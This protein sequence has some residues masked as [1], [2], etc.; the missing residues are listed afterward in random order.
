MSIGKSFG[1]SIKASDLHLGL[2]AFFGLLEKHSADGRAY[3]ELCR[4]TDAASPSDSTCIETS[5]DFRENMIRALTTSLL[6]SFQRL[7]ELFQQLQVR[8]RGGSVLVVY[9]GDQGAW[10]GK[11]DQK[12]FSVHVIDFA[13]ATFVPGQGPDQG[14]LLGLRSVAAL[15]QEIIDATARV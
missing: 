6:P 15:L 9:E 8:I 3:G 14:I 4:S 11:T 13:H 2:K 1:K 10:Y 7:Q 12:P 5:E